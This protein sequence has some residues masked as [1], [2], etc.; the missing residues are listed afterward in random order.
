MT[1]NKIRFPVLR[2]LRVI[3]YELFPGEDR[4]GLDHT[5]ESGVTVVV[6]VNGLGR[7]RC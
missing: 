3:N 5:F 2:R 1:P 7:R 4:K 6:G